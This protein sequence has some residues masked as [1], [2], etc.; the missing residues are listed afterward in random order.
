MV[1]LLSVKLRWSS[2]TTFLITAAATNYC[3]T[4]T[5]VCVLPTIRLR[6]AA[7]NEGSDRVPSRPHEVSAATATVVDD[8][9]KQQ[10]SRQHHKQAYKNV[11]VPKVKELDPFSTAVPFWG[12]TS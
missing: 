5:A 8:R 4:A 7:D 2:D 11:L 6:T 9:Q 3:G 12:Q 10:P 1:L